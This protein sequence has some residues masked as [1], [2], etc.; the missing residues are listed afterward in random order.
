MKRVIRWVD[1][2]VLLILSALVLG[3]VLPVSRPVLDGVESVGDVAI[4][5]LFG[6]YGM[7]LRTTEVLGSLRN[8][9]LQGGILAST[10]VLFPAFGLMISW[11]VSPI[12]GTA[13]AAGVL[14]LSLLPST[15]QS[16]VAF[17]SVARGN[18]AGAISAATIS[19]VVGMVA[20]PL[21]VLWLMGASGATGMGGIRSVL[22]Q[23]LLPFVIGQLLQPFVGNWVRAHK[24]ITMVLDRGTVTL[25]VFS[26]VASATADG[27]WQEVSAV[28]LVGLLGVS[29]LLLAVMLAIT[30][31]GGK[32]LGLDVADRI[33][34]LMC[35]SKKSLAT[36]LPMALVLFPAAAAATIAVPVIIFHQLQLLVCAAIA[37]RLASR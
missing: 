10:Y 4:F 2:F 36:G 3:L 19:N 22:L 18:V 37:R 25:L 24:P 5:L 30:W 32:G 16:S 31:W 12:V 13:L 14:Y 15:V 8:W 9:R 21:L 7:R 27:V 35:G 23:L 6:V 26:A 20:T 11:A 1:P 29:G 17:V 33:A 34:L 28:M